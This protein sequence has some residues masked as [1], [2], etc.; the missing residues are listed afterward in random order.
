MYRNGVLMIKKPKGFLLVISILVVL[1]RKVFLSCDSMKP[2]T[3]TKP[4]EVAVE[5]D[6]SG[7]RVCRLMG[8][9]PL[10]HGHGGRQVPLRGFGIP[11]RGGM[12]WRWI[13]ITN[14]Y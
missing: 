8:S 3:E 13:N 7:Q 10:A 5:S 9:E 6:A 14:M 11:G 4:R 1:T 2:S 12:A